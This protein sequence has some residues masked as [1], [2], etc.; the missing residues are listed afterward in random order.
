MK[1]NTSVTLDSELIEQVRNM[2]ISVSRFTEKAME[3][4][5]SDGF[6]DFTLSLKIKMYQDTL[7]EIRREQDA[8]DQRYNDLEEQRISLETGLSDAQEQYEM[9][10]SIGK[11]SKLTQRLN[12]ITIMNNY[13]PDIIVEKAHDIIK[14]MMILNPDFNLEQHIQSLRRVIND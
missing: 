8:C 14:E 3:T 1:R 13:N 11:L 7:N 12:R 2:G 10:I 6:D 5:I 4:L 9:A